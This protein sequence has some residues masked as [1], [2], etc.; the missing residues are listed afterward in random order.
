[1]KNTDLD[2]FTTYIAIILSI[3]LSDV[4]LFASVYVGSEVGYKKS[5]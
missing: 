1:M 3:A 4:K 2:F 5:Q